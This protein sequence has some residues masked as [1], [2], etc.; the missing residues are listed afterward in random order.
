M[1]CRSQYA[2]TDEGGSCGTEWWLT[3]DKK[4]QAPVEYMTIQLARVDPCRLCH[5]IVNP[6][7]SCTFP[8]FDSTRSRSLVQYVMEMPYGAA[9]EQSLT[10]PQK[11]NTSF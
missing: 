3:V 1:Q 9:Q 11:L 6:T 8:C 4:S 10:S 5:Q 2:A 7:K